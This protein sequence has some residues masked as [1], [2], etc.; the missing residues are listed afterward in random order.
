MRLLELFW[1]FI[2][3]SSGYSVH[4]G[5][6]WDL[7]CFVRKYS[8]TKVH[9]IAKKFKLLVTF[10]RIFDILDFF[11]DSLEGF[12]DFS[13]PVRDF[14]DASMNFSWDF[15][16]LLESLGIFPKPYGTFRDFSCFVRDLS[17]SLVKLFCLF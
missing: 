12:R 13:R 1:E 6:F 16:T 2:G 15:P 8:K 17:A 10:I 3:T 4:A 14:F 5:N 9:F 11:Q 7:S